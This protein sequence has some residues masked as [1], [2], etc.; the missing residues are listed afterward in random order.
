[1]AVDVSPVL[2]LENL[3]LRVGDLEENLAWYRDVV[4]LRE[5]TR[6]DA[7]VYLAVGAKPT[8]DVS[9]VAGG[10]GLEYFSIAV[11]DT[12]ALAAIADRLHAG[13]VE[14]SEVDAPDP[15]ISDA[16]EFA[17]PGGQRVRVVVP[18]ERLTYTVATDVRFGAVFAPKELH[19]VNLAVTDLP[20][21]ED[22][23][24]T[25]LDMA[26]SDHVHWE[27]GGP[28]GLGFWRFGENHHDIA[29]VSTFGDGLHHFAFVVSGV[30][31]LVAMADRLAA[32]GFRNVENGI[33]RHGAGN[34]LFLYTRDPTGNIVEFSTDLARINDRAAP[35]RVWENAGESGNL[36]GDMDPP[37]SFLKTVT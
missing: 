11:N 24:V 7:K 30:G 1:M 22:F 28:L 27:P 15:Q 23:L 3:A 16:I 21:L 32:C 10:T 19:H 33:G 29:A 37:E 18:E 12:E 17:L 36:W 4:G 6:T 34:N 2:R 26:I 20:A 5:V 25:H 9:L 14:V 35:Y 8:W 31:D 13:D